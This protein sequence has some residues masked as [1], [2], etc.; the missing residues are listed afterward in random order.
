MDT[1]DARIQPPRPGEPTTLGRH[2]VIGRLGSGGMGVVYLADGP[3]GKVAVKLV[4]EELADDPDFRR[5]FQREVQA[6]FRVG[7]TRT[8]RLVDFELDADRPWLATEFVDAPNL[9]THIRTIG[10]LGEDDQITLATG[11]A[12]AL[13]S[14]HASGLIHRDLKPSNVLWTPHGP[15]VIDFGIAAAAD[16]AALTVSG[17]FVG[18]PG[19]HSPEQVSG[20]D[21]TPA[22]DVFAWGAILCFAATGEPP[23]GSGPAPAVLH[24]VLLAEP[25]I[26]LDALAAPLHGPVTS[27]LARDPAERPTAVDLLTALVGALPEGEPGLATRQL[28]TSSALPP[29]PPWSATVAPAGAGQGPGSAAGTGKSPGSANAGPPPADGDGSGGRGKRGRRSRARIA[30]LAGVASIVAGAAVIAAVVLSLQGGDDDGGSS[31]S[32]SSDLDAGT[33]SADAPWRLRIDNRIDSSGDGSSGCTIVVSDVTTG[34]SRTLS[35]LWGTKTYQVAQTGEFRF[36]VNNEQCEVQGLRT[37]GDTGLPFAQESSVGD[38]EA[39]HTEGTVQVEVV[40][41]NGGDKCELAL[42]ALSDGRMLDFTTAS[43]N[44]NQVSLNAGQPDQVYLAEPSCGIR[45]LSG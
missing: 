12:E 5:R 8:V 22:T 28:Q 10:R 13:L 40:D 26:D 23:F 2:R 34:E 30:A 9:A 4:R 7:G 32:S 45:V 31:A 14:I 29:T 37:T 6:C 33:F 21:A 11:L 27:S 15:K 1:T 42:H 43:I 20:Q 36:D 25:T 39:F 38:T 35:G 19:W 18:T 3:F 41:F 17:Q 24:R 44:E 16:A